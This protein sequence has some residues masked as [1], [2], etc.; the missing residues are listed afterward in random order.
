MPWRWDL[1]RSDFNRVS[2]LCTLIFV[3][4]VVYLGATTDAPRVLTLIFQWFP[5]VVLPLL[6]A[7]VYSTVGRRGRAHLPLEPAQEGR[8]GRDARHPH[9]RSALPVLRHLHPRRER[10]ERARRGLLR[11]RHRADRGRALERAGARAFGPLVWGGLC[12]CGGGGGLGRARGTASRAARRG[13][14]GARVA[15]GVDA[16]G[17]RSLPEQ[18]RASAPSGG[19]SSPTASSC[20]WSR[21]RARRCRCLLREATYNVFAMPAWLAVDA[22]FEPGAARGRRHHLAAGAGRAR[23]RRG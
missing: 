12:S 13:G 14:G 23:P 9:A 16:A 5:L 10:G 15:G 19:S 1:A 7:Q 21:A 3:G 8:R 11:G 2:D 6:L 22:G 4:L 18:H 20:G 17:H